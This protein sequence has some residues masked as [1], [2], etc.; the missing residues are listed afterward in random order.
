LALAIGANSL[1]AFLSELYT[2]REF[3][4]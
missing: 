4:A 2:A 3:V 1:T